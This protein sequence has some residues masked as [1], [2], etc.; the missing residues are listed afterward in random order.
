MAFTDTRLSESEKSL[1]ASM[2]GRTL[3][4]LVHDEYIVNSTT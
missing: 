4:E 3:E 1:L 2:V